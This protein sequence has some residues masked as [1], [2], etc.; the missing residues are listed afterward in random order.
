MVWI[1]SK[2]LVWMTHKLR[3]GDFGESKPENSPAEHAPRL[4]FR[5]RLGNRSVFIYSRSASVQDLGRVQKF[6]FFAFMPFPSPQMAFHAL[7]WSTT[8]PPRVGIRIEY[9]TQE[10]PFTRWLCGLDLLISTHGPIIFKSHSLTRAKLLEVGLKL[11]NHN[12]MQRD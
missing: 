5:A 7:C 8:A 1:V 11:Q 12:R 4:P 3:K 2:Y 10:G 9:W 6:Y